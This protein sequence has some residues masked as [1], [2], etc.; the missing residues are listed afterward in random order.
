MRLEPKIKAQA[1]DILSELGLTFSDA[2]NLFM[3]QVINHRGLPFDIKIPNAETQAAI[4][5][6][7]RGEGERMTL[8]EMRASLLED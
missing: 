5:A 4:E 2:V 7:R 8:D 1:N 3:R 6:S